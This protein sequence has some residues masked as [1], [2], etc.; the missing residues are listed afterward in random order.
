[1]NVQQILGKYRRFRAASAESTAFLPAFG[2]CLTDG[3]LDDAVATARKHGKSHVASVVSAGVSEA[4]DTRGVPDDATQVDLVARALERSTVLA[5]SDLKQGLGA[6]A[7]IGATA[8]FI[9][10]F[11]T[12]VGI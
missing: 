2:K 1:M 8:P 11:G 10:L 4:M 6:L 3:K 7:T 9:G 12:V 5:L